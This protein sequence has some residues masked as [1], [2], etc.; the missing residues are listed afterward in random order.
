MVPREVVPLIKAEIIFYILAHYCKE[1]GMKNE[2]EYQRNEIAVF[3]FFF[4]QRN[5]RWTAG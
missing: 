2:I 4:F 3:F 5:Q 1:R